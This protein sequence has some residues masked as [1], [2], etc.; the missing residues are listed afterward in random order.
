MQHF[1]LGVACVK[2]ENIFRPLNAFGLCR[3]DLAE[4]LTEL[5]R[6]GCYQSL[7]LEYFHLYVTILM[8]MIT[9]LWYAIY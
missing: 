4:Q 2:V 5:V 6:E 1:I 7:I 9:V 3:P 8:P